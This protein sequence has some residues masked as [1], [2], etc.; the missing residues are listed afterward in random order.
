MYLNDGVSTKEAAG[1]VKFLEKQ[2][3]ENA[4]SKYQA[5]VIWINPEAKDD[6]AKIAEEV[7]LK[8]VHVAYLEKGAAD[9]AIKTHKINTDKEV[10]ITALFYVGKRVTDTIVNP[11]LG[12]DKAY[13]DFG[14]AI[15][16]TLK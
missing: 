2:C 16:K 3:A 9:K 6:I 13:L 10:K 14:A 15:K 11:D 1:L 4:D 12:K 8:Q 7:G 5:F